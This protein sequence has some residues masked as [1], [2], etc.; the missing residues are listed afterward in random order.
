MKMQPSRRL[1]KDDIGREELIQ[2]LL[3]KAVAFPNHQYVPPTAAELVALRK[4]LK[5]TKEVASKKICISLRT[6][7]SRESTKD[8]A[9]VRQEEFAMIILFLL[10][11]SKYWTQ[12][13]QSVVGT[14]ES[15][16]EPENNLAGRRQHE[17][18]RLAIA[19]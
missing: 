16:I 11:G 8:H 2:S 1:S 5:L 3:D 4:D 15:D 19:A 14:S 6:W 10:R 12:I 7:A 13:Q 9:Q 17:R 18:V